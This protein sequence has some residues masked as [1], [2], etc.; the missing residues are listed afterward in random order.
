VRIEERSVLVGDGIGLNDSVGSWSRRLRGGV[1]WLIE[2]DEV[3]MY[4]WSIEVF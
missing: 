1:R 4:G 3:M 2:W